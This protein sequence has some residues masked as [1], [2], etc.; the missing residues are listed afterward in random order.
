MAWPGEIRFGL[1]SRF[2]LWRRRPA[3][4]TDFDAAKVPMMNNLDRNMLAGYGPERRPK[5]MFIT[6]TGGWGWAVGDNLGAAVAATIAQCQ[7]NYPNVAC[8][9]YAVNNRVVF[10][11]S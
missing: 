11:A 5:A 1:A 9:L 4:P 6:V 2:L 10:T 3:P 8:L 7:K